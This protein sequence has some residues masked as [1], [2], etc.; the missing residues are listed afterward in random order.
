MASDSVPSLEYDKAEKISK[1]LISQ[2]HLK[3]VFYKTKGVV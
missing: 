2:G 1:I 3:S